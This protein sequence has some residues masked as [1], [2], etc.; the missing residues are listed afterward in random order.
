[1][2][3]AL[4]KQQPDSIPSRVERNIAVMEE[5]LHQYPLHDPQVCDQVAAASAVASGCASLLGISCRNGAGVA[6]G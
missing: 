5:C 1:M 3:R 2:W 6:A 4:Q